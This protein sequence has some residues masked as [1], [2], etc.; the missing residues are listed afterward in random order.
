VEITIGSLVDFCIQLA[1]YAFVLGF[2]GWLVVV[3]EQVMR[4]GK[5]DLSQGGPITKIAL[6]STLLSGA[7]LAVAFIGFIFAGTWWLWGR[8]AVDLSPASLALYSIII[9]PA[10]LLLSLLARIIARAIGGTVDA[11]QA[12][13]CVFLGLELNGFLHTL[14]MSYMLFFI[15]GS[16]AV[17]GLLG[18]GVWALVRL[19]Q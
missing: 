13:D 9:G 15:T 2:L 5:F 11:S 10:P 18:S 3:L 19:F 6:V 7:G 16:L 4:R 1:M 8:F 14:F 12:R 17:L